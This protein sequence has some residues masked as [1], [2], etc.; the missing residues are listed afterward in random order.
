MQG[1]L[2][3]YSSIAQVPYDI[4]QLDNS[5]TLLISNLEVTNRIDIL[6]TRMDY[7]SSLVDALDHEVADEYTFKLVWIIIVLIAISAIVGW[8]K[9]DSHGPKPKPKE[10]KECT[11]VPPC[12]KIN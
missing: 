12:I 10:A 6:N 2:N 1:D 8:L 11:E 4:H 5:Y 3:L 7:A 9:I